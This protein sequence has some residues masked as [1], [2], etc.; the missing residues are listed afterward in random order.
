MDLSKQVKILLMVD[1]NDKRKG[2]LIVYS[3]YKFISVR[4]IQ[5]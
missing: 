1:K 2:R 5:C 3:Y 4:N